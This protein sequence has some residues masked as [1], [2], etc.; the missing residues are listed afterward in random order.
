MKFSKIE[1]ESKA[2]HTPDGCKE[3][4]NADWGK[5]C[6]CERTAPFMSYRLTSGSAPTATIWKEEKATLRVD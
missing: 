1:R 4:E 2:E 5:H 3:A 6:I